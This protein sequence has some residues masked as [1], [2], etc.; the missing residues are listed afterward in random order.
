MWW[1]KKNRAYGPVVMIFI[2]SMVLASCGSGD[3]EEPIEVRDFPGVAPALWPYFIRFED[4][5]RARGID[6]NL[7][8]SGITAKIE[9]IVEQEIA[10][11]CHFNPREPNDLV[12]DQQFW[13]RARDLFRE[14]VVFHEL[15]HCF[16]FRDHKEDQSADRTCVS[17]MRSGNGDCRDNYTLGTRT[18][19]LDELFDPEF[20]RDIF[21]N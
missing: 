4:E 20:A 2:V 9:Q 18:A 15:G 1:D 7:K 16:L 3:D 8:A 6:V 5:G 17:V 19:Y 21:I 14:F 11:V 12:I 13:T 10:G